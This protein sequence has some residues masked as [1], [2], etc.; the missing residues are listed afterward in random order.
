MQIIIIYALIF[1]IAPIVFELILRLLFTSSRKSAEINYRLK[2]LRKSE[3]HKQTFGELLLRRGI[4][5]NEPTMLTGDWVMK[6]YVQSGL[7]L[8]VRQRY[9]Y[10]SLWLLASFAIGYLFVGG[11]SLTLFLL[12]TAMFFGGIIGLLLLK[13]KKRIAN[14]ILQLADAIDIII[15][16]ISAGH[17][18]NTAI[19]LVSR[20]MKDPIGTEFGLITDQLTYGAE[21]DS[22]MIDLYYR[23][24]ADEL[25]LL[26]V[27]LSVQQGTGGNLRE[28]LENL[29]AMIRARTL[30]KAKIRAISAEGR[31]TAVIMAIFPFGLF[32]MIRTLAPSYFD[33]LWESGY[34]TIVFTVCGI[35][36]VIGMIILN[37]LVRFD[38]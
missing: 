18:L 5:T 14:F 17:P 13:R 8:S 16:S 35:F 23:V 28:I 15:R 20:E 11:A 12:A 38:F 21:L 25:K 2:K 31:I 29:S 6:L 37:R 3:D 4:D 36:M 9:A 26:A 24:G 10:A 30:M 33:A 7:I 34:G 19:S 27:T 22:A 1:V 32:L